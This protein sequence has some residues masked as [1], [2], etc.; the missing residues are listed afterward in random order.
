MVSRGQGGV[1][2]ALS[3]GAQGTRE[4]WPCDAGVAYYTG[5]SGSGMLRDLIGGCGGGGGRGGAVATD[6]PDAKILANAG[7][8]GKH[9][10]RS[11]RLV[12]CGEDA[13]LE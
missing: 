10:A 5:G 3:W 9:A 6:G 11:G 12:C 4:S 1:T 7:C 2:A 8:S 13:L